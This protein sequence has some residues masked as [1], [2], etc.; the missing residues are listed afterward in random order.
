MG[1]QEQVILIEKEVSY[2]KGIDLGKEDKTIEFILTAYSKGLT[3]DLIADLVKVPVS[4]VQE[5]INN[6]WAN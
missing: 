3:I 2:N 1:I 5:I 6:H 4:K